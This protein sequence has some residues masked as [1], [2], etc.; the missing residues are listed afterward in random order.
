MPGEIN[1][2]PDLAQ[3][4]EP[5]K[6]TE[7]GVNKPD[8]KDRIANRNIMGGLKSALSNLQTTE[9]DVN[10]Q[11]I[12]NMVVDTAKYGEF[13]FLGNMT[14]ISISELGC[15]AVSISETGGQSLNADQLRNN[16]ALLAEVNKAQMDIL[17]QRVNSNDPKVDSAW[18]G[19]SE[20]YNPKAFP[21]L[22]RVVGNYRID[23]LPLKL[24][25]EPN[26]TGKMME[27][28]ASKMIKGALLNK[29]K[30]VTA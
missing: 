19:M 1:V 2:M 20:Q 24:A 17:Q 9:A 3:V 8:N 12:D 18:D 25:S 13:T 28:H 11:K 29:N 26:N 30:N 5:N 6:L 21:E 10:G 15:Y 14:A 4:T 16:Q 27:T 23:V 22:Q 7:I